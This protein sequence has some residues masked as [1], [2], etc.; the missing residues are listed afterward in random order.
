MYFKIYNPC[1]DSNLNNLN[2]KG[3][4]LNANVKDYLYTANV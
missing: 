3:L 4:Y 2:N 1:S